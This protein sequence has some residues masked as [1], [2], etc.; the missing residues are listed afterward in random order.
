MRLTLT[1]DWL[2]P[3]LVRDLRQ[4][5]RSRVFTLA[6]LLLQGGMAF[7]VVLGVS[8]SEA[9]EV[10]GILNAILWGGAD[11]LLFYGDAVPL[12]S[13]LVPEFSDNRL[14][15]L[16]LTQMN[17]RGLMLGKWLSFCAQGAMVAVSLLPLS[18]C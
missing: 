17:A 7:F 3:M 16:K 4:V 18:E 10:S 9:G 14:D 6:F 11:H 1:S 12:H 8:S 2:N 5:L 13:S 15:L